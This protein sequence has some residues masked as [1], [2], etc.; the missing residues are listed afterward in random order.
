MRPGGLRAVRNGLRPSRYYLTR[1]NCLY[2]SSET[3]VLEEIREEDIKEKGRIHPGKLL[4]ADTVGHRLKTD[5]EL[6]ENMIVPM[7]K[8][9]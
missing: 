3:G 2:L 1:D 9:E 7:V 5:E 4:V 8:N 6:K